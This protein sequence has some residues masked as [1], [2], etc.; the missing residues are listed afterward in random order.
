MRAGANRVTAGQ[1]PDPP[2]VPRWAVRLTRSSAAL[3][4]RLCDL[5][6]VGLGLLGRGG[7]GQVPLRAAAK[8]LG[9]GRVASWAPTSRP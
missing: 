9:I 3:V 7:R 6:Q 5:L 1:D 4:D 2:R 8:A